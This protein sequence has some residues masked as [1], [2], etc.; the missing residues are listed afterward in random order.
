MVKYGIR[1]FQCRVGLHSSDAYVI[2]Y[3]L[4]TTSLKITYL[5][6]QNSYQS[7]Y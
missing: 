5:H 7:A 2:F 3:T 6:C 1:A 4:K